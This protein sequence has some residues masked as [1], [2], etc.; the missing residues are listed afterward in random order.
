[1]SSMAAS[2]ARA[3]WDVTEGLILATVEIHAT[4]ER[5][6]Q[7]LASKEICEW[8]VRPTRPFGVFGAKSTQNSAPKRAFGAKG[9]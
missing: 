6:F 5:V 3:V 2:S 4:P 1:M 8:W 7:A 9:T